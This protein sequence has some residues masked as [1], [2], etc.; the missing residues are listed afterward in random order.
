VI[1]TVKRGLSDKG[2]KKVA[3][4]GHSLGASIAMLDALALKSV[5]GDDIAITTTLF[6]LPR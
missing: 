1:D 4:I 6:G 2:V 3:V 5:L